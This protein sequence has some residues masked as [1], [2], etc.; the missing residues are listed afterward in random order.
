VSGDDASWDLYIDAIIEIV[1]DGRTN[2]VRGPNAVALP[3]DAPVFVLTAYNPGGVD[4]EDAENE[5]AERFLES[6]LAAAGV[7]S[8]P[9]FGHS[10]DESW[11]EPGVAVASFDRAR[12]CALGDRYGQLAVYE[13]TDDEVYVVRCDDA[14]VVRT[15]D[16][17]E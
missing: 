3:A 11:C 8:W 5:A 15:A 16:R 4:R 2:S 14:A 10:R 12:A 1:V 17:R 13:L 9:A 6:E 7:T